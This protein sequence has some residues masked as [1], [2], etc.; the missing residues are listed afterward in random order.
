MFGPKREKKTP[1]Q[2]PPREMTTEER[3]RAALNAIVPSQSQ[4]RVMTSDE[5]HRVILNEIYPAS[6]QL[7]AENE[8]HSENTSEP[9][10]G[11]QAADAA[12]NA[13]SAGFIAF[14]ATLTF[15]MFDKDE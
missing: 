2:V 5:R 10:V 15:T 4:P 3:H 9:S 8:T 1:S 6:N 11:V 7:D 12:V 14:F 13:V